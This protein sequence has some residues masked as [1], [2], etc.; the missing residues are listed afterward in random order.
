VLP[1]IREDCQ[2]A[3]IEPILAGASRGASTAVGTLIRHPDSFRA[4]IGISG[5]YPSLAFM[6]GVTG[7]RLDRLRQRSLLLGSGEGDYD[8]PEESRALSQTLTAKG[9]SCRFS[10]WGRAHDHTW[11]TWREFFPRLLAEAVPGA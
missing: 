2:D 8:R 5:I 4:A 7:P 6:K 10:L 1:R 11:S 9:V 3:Q